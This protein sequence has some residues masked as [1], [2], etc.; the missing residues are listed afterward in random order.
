MP[1]YA[2]VDEEVLKRCRECIHFEFADGY[3]Y[4]RCKR[5]EEHVLSNGFLLHDCPSFEEDD[6]SEERILRRNW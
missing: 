4:S 1:G 5:K 6:R 3:F 2:R